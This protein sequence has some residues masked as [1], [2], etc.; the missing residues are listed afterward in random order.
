M[1]LLRGAGTHVFFKK[2]GY[3]PFLSKEPDTFSVSGSFFM[4]NGR[5]GLGRA[6]TEKRQQ[7]SA[8]STLCR[9]ARFLRAGV[10]RWIEGTQLGRG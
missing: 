3:K 1:P 8:L 5:R 2:S 9:I 10:D 7:V 4:E 6:Q